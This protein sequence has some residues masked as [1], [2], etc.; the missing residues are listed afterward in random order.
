MASAG[1][2]QLQQIGVNTF[3][4]TKRFH[5]VS[6]TAGK[7]VAE[8]EVWRNVAA[9]EREFLQDIPVS[10][11]HSYF[12]MDGSLYTEPIR[13]PIFE[14]KNQI[15]KRER[16]GKTYDGFSHFESIIAS[17]NNT[18]NV[19]V[20][21]SPAGKA[22]TE[23][24][25]DTITFD[26]GRLY[27]AFTH[28]GNESKHI[29][30]KINENLFPIIPLLQ[31]L[32]K[33]SG[34]MHVP[35]GSPSDMLNHYLEHPFS[36][37]IDTEELFGLLQY[38]VNEWGDQTA[39]IARRQTKNPETFSLGT[40]FAEMRKQLET[41]HHTKKQSVGSDITDTLDIWGGRTERM[42]RNESDILGYYLKAIKP[43]VDQNGGNYTL[44]GCS[45]TSTVSDVLFKSTLNSMK[46]ISLASSM[47]GYGSAS[48][49]LS[50]GGSDR[51]EPYAC[52]SCHRVYEGEKKD[53]TNW[54]KQCECGFR[55]NC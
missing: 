45:T 34:D 38:F 15:D 53:G 8:R 42:I 21:Y 39:Y 23:P 11:T 14:I 51:Y 17:K 37:H 36:T 19:V 32:Q 26:S 27:F 18:E 33:N 43:Y 46:S 47:S 54:R 22:G 44:Y 3:R 49:I 12:M 4:E 20:W 5:E 2:Q 6:E 52:P 28:S 31:F 29:D 10:Q 13:H 7:S 48:R 55:F 50:E 25:F 40:I 35:Q 30:I 24:P 1:E 41:S 16:S 9:Y